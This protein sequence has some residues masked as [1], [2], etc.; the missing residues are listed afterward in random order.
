MRVLIL[1][2]LLL[3]SSSLCP[4]FAQEQEKPPQAKPPVE[5]PQ[6]GAARTDQNSE[7]PRDQRTGRDQSRA[8]DREM[9]PDWRMR[10]DDGGR[11]GRDSR[12]M[13]SE[14]AMRRDGARMGRDDREM[15]PAPGMQRD[16][17]WDRG[18][19]TARGD[20]DWDHAD[21]DD[22]SRGYLDDDRPRRRVKICVEYENGD[23]YCR[24]RR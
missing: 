7:Q 4:S 2:A 8:D 13:G 5:A 19:Y 22:D 12:E 10:R 24:Y 14:E 18:R 11:I 17:D 6:T 15:G 9:G 20:R 23:E 16:R 21:R 1:A 3:G